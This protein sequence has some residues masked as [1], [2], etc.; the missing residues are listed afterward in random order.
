MTLSVCCDVQ[1]GGASR[2]F[3][4]SCCMPR[5]AVPG[6]CLLANLS[7][8]AASCSTH[9]EGANILPCS[10]CPQSLQGTL[11]AHL[12]VSELVS[13]PLHDLLLELLFVGQHLG[14][15]VLGHLGSLPVGPVLGCKLASLLCKLHLVQLQGTQHM[16]STSGV[17]LGRSTHLPRTMKSC[18]TS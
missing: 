10:I 11:T 17:L 16:Q 5:A 14:Q 7:Q 3:P 9:P 2:E 12:E 13:P 15:T 18:I 6:L 1:A 4:K 8:E